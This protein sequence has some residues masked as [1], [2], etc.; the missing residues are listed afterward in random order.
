VSEPVV[1]LAALIVTLGLLITIH[2]FGH[3]WV[4][5][6]LGVRVLRFSVGFGRAL[7]KRKG[8]DGTEYV[9][10]AIPLGGY[11][12]MLDEREGDVPPD[13]LKYAF[14]RKSVWTRVAVV[15]A[16]PFANFLF[17]IVAYALMFSIG[18][19]GTK[20]VVGDVESGSIAEYAGF[21]DGDVIVSIGGE[22]TPTWSM[23]GMSL[24]EQGIDG[25]QLTI[26]VR[27]S[28][29]RELQRTV[30]LAALGETVDQG[31]LLDEIG[32]VPWRPSLPAVVD[33]L[34]SDGAAER[35]GLLPGDLIVSA[36]SVEIVDWQD[37]ASFVRNRPEQPILTEVD[38]DGATVT[39]TLTPDAV[40]SGEGLIGRIGAFGRVPD[41]L[42]DEMSVVVR[43]GPVEALGAAMGRTW[44]MSLF[45]LRMLGRMLVGKASLENLSGP[46]TIAQFAGQTASIG[47]TAFLAFLA[48]VSISLGVLNLLP[49]PVLD[50]GHLL[51]YLIEAVKGSPLSEAV[52]AAG[53]RIGLVILL[54]LMGLAFFNDIS[55]LVGS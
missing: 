24:L 31:A 10:A 30:D 7:V 47:I 38:R 55:R 42:Y 22:S 16:G 44:E 46:I 40:E 43:Y 41:G 51:Y 1:S 20:P 52:Q 21:R 29:G 18:V 53:Q 6:R 32:L 48:L 3:F 37:W 2:E 15:L 5:R 54:M 50:G 13:E 14:N 34:V 33:R 4:A 49:V 36:N 45:T 11:V 9:V 23:V 39:L 35:D 25:G 26:S 8:R 28:A 27:D 19:S 12:R 17:A